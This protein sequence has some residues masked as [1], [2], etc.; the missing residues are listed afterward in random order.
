MTKLKLKDIKENINIDLLKNIH[1][2]SSKC[3][4]WI[5]KEEDML[6]INFEGIHGG[7]P[8]YTSPNGGLLISF[9]DEEIL[10]VG[11]FFK[12]VNKTIDPVFSIKTEN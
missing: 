8:V 2:E 10:T 12:G 7:T 11:I 3:N 9:D 6:I 5:N 4:V 1:C